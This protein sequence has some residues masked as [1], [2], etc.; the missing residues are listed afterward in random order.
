M[1]I[2]HFSWEFPPVL[3]GGL[4]TFV[5]EISQKLKDLGNEITVFTL[6]RNNELPTYENW[7]GIEVYRPKTLDLSSTYLLFANPEF[8]SW[9]PHFKFFA[10]VFSYNTIS[11][12]Q[13]VNM[14][15]RKERKNYD[16]IHAHDW[17]GI[18]G[19][20]IVKK[21]INLPLIFHVHSTEIGRSIGRGSHI[22][23]DIEFEG[24]Q[25]A[26]CVITVSH[27]MKDELEKL[28]FSCNKIHVCWNGIDAEKYDPQR[29]SNEEKNKLRR[30]YGIDE[31]DNMLLFIGRLVTVKGPDKLINAMP[32]VLQDFPNTKLVIL[33]VGD[34]EYSLKSMVDNLGLRDKVIFRTEFVSEYERILHYASSDCVV[35]PSIY[36][37]FGIVCTEAMSMEKPVVVGAR[38]TSGFREQVIPCGENQSG[39]HIN[40]FDPKDIAWG[41]KQVLQDRRRAIELGKNGRKQVLEKFTI[42]H[43]AER[44]LEIYKEFI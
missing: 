9:G 1:R 28:G 6:N 31:N 21:E 4:G 10:D 18:I 11:A 7:N 20:M 2:V 12:S 15:I 27:A 33:G 29:I 30:I 43:V 17:L 35:L 22:I 19:G 34:M 44:L 5:T 14:L 23:K 36:E 3:Y 42:D 41:I 37:P 40:P 39:Y 38:G 32:F 24:G 8:R 25:E 26:D 13:L 16:I